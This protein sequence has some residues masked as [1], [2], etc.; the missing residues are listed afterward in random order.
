MC[1]TGVRTGV[2]RGGAA[3]APER[4]DAGPSRRR[5]VEREAPGGGIV[6]LRV[7]D[8]TGGGRGGPDRR[9][10]SER[11]ARRFRHRGRARLAGAVAV[12]AEVVLG[13]EGAVERT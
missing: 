2:E 1:A 7:E 12:E 9:E 13:R 11:V 4:G 10:V 8:G 3:G 6:E 5:E